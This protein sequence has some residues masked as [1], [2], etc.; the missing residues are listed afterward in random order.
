M[1]DKAMIMMLGGMFLLSFATA[2]LEISDGEQI[3]IILEVEDEPSGGGG[4]NPFDQSLNTT[5]D[6]T[7]NDLTATGDLTD[8]ACFTLEAS[9]KLS[10]NSYWKFGLN[11]LSAGEGVEMIADGSVTQYGWTC[12]NSPTAGDTCTHEI[13]VRTDG[14]TLIEEAFISTN[15]NDAFEYNRD[16][17]TFNQGDLIQMYYQKTGSFCLSASKISCG[18]F[19][20]VVYD[21]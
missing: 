2:G 14:S 15:Q 6:V 1:I 21:N 19:V 9:F 10:T 17:N 3:G 8:T 5:D 7:F 13:E 12:S 11:V 4:E 18:G 20:C 16:V